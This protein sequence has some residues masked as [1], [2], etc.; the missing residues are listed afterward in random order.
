MS[1]TTV[2]GSMKIRNSIPRISSSESWDGPD[3]SQVSCQMKTESIVRER[4]ASRGACQDQAA[5]ERSTWDWTRPAPGA[6]R[7]VILLTD[8]VVD[9]SEE[10]PESAASR[11]RNHCKWNAPDASEPRFWT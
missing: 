9:V 5:L 1:S 2:C 7:H 8:G 4:R 3:E 10:A 11:E 6:R